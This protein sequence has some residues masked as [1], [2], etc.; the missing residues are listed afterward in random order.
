VGAAGPG[1]IAVLRGRLNRALTA[2]AT[3][4]SG[5][6]PETIV[7]VNGLADDLETWVF[8]EAELTEAGYRLLMFDNR[9]IGQ[10]SKPAGP[11]SARLLA[12]EA[13]AEEAETGFDPSA[14]ARRRP[15]RPNLAG[16]Q[17]H[18]SRLGLR[19]DDDT[20]QTIRR[21]AERQQRKVSDIVRKAIDRYLEAS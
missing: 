15:G 16:G 7:L 13:L 9:G 20:Y 6:G 8:Q 18:S 12:E 4:R 3:E 19:L 2:Q 1:G 11:Y 5:N 10:T 17:G 14:L 21:L